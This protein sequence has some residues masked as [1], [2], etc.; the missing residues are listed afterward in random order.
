VEAG[1]ACNACHQY[2]DPPGLALEHYDALGAY[3]QTD[4]G[5]PITVDDQVALPDGTTGPRV[6]SAADLASFIATSDAFK[7]CVTKK[8]TEYALGR[9]LQV[10]DDVYA[11]VNKNLWQ[12]LDRLQ[13]GSLIQR[14][15]LSDQFRTRHG[16]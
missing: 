7:L 8:V 11:V 4:Q 16:G 3:R 10:T 1:A 2:L 13:L 15:V 14:L 6:R 12:K 9:A 5:L